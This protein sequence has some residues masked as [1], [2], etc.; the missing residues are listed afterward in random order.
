MPDNRRLART[1]SR[2]GL[3]LI[4]DAVFGINVFAGPVGDVTGIGYVVAVAI[5]DNTVGDLALIGEAAFIAVLGFE[6][7][8]Q[9]VRLPAAGQRRPCRELSQTGNRS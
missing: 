6:S 9:G 4:G 7:E 3:A 2:T 8:L 5:L 1:P